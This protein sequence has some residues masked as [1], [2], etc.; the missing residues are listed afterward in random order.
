M[1]WNGMCSVTMTL[2]LI[3]ASTAS[4]RASLA[5]GAGTKMTGVD[6]PLVTGE[7]LDDDPGLGVHEHAHRGPPDEGVGPIASSTTDRTA[8]LRSEFAG[9]PACCRI[10]IP[11]FSLF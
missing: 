7:P 1:S 8:S 9:T 6:R 11:S 5:K 10:A 2:N 4:M 3:P